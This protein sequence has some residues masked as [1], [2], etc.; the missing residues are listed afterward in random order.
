MHKIGIRTQEIQS[1][2]TTRIGIG[3]IHPCSPIDIVTEEEVVRIGRVAT[4]VKV[5]Q[6]ILVLSMDVAAY[7]DRGLQ[8]HQHR[9]LQEQLSSLLAQLSDFDFWKL[10]LDEYN[11]CTHFKLKQVEDGYYGS[12]I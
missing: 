4:F 12:Y 11:I 10:Y 9:L 6:Q 8:F 7:G 3:I 2:S 1:D 5:S